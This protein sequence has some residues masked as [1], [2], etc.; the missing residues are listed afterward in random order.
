MSETE[1]KGL[2]RE[3][4]EESALG[5]G[6]LAGFDGAEPPAPDWFRRMVAMPCR[7]GA[8]HVEGA[9]VTWRQWGDATK[10]GLLFSHGMG[11]YSL[12][13]NNPHL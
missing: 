4:A 10:P 8:T 12:L 5:Q 2:V 11:S 9:R 1:D 3:Q 13:L 7:E 6:P